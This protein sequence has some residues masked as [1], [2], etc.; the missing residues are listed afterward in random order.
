MSIRLVNP[1]IHATIV[2]DE[3]QADFWVARGFER[4]SVKAPVRAP[5]KKSEKK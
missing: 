1:G 3:S 4:E 2:V 5:A